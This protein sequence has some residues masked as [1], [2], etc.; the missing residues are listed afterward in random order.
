M[1]KYVFLNIPAYGHVNPTFPVVQELVRR[2]EEV[3]YFLTEEFRSAVEATGAEFRPYRPFMG[4]PQ[5]VQSQQTSPSTSGLPD[6][7]RKEQRMQPPAMA[8]GGYDGPFEI[9][10]RVRAEKP[11]VILYDAMHLWARTI[12]HVLRVPAILSCPMLVA[13]EHYNPL[14]QHLNLLDGQIPL[15]VSIPPAALQG[16]QTQITRMC[17]TYNVPT[18]DMRDFYAYTEPL[19]IV[20]IPRAFHPAG[21][22]FDDRYIFVGPSLFPHEEKEVLT[23]SS[24]G[25]PGQSRLYVS[26]GTIF[27]D[28]PDF[29]NLCFDAFDEHSWQVVLALGNRVDAA[30]LG[31]APANFQIASYVQQA[32][33]F[34]HTDVFVTHAGMTSVTESL[35][36]GVPMVAIPQQYEQAVTAQRIAELGLG[37]VLDRHTV[38]SE[39]L[40]QAVEYVQAKP[41][42]RERTQAMQKMVR[43]AGGYR[44]AAD[45]ILHFA[46]SYL[47]C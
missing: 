44:R 11:D 10:E 30:S 32:E 12:A 23:P 39:S 40:R 6:S 20:F 31:P 22:T 42:F 17:E 41:A 2:G 47:T 8:K 34:P 43:N 9:L 25:N 29:F 37:V 28:Q 4:K 14:K 3:V 13:N 36:Y 33:V 24:S 35:Y 46:Q 26:L 16:I 38:T 21:D 27:N 1:A 18:L 45:A 7:E 15:P 5:P 19:N